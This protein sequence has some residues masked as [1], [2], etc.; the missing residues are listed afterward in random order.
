MG[1]RTGGVAGLDAQDVN[2]EVEE[3]GFSC[4]RSAERTCD[5]AGRSFVHVSRFQW[6]TELRC[7]GVCCT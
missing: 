2:H 7:V 1:K 3:D 5:K 4:R 6:R